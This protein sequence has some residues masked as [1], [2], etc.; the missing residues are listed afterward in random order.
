MFRLFICILPVVLVSV[1]VHADIAGRSDRIIAVVS[2]RPIHYTELLRE[3]HSRRWVVAEPARDGET[4]EDYWLKRQGD[5]TRLQRLYQRALQSLKAQKVQEQLL[6]SHGLWSYADDAAFRRHLGEVN[7]ERT[8][9]KGK[10]LIYG[11]DQY[12]TQTFFEYQNNTALIR[13]KEILVA[14]GTL[15][16]TEEALRAQYAEMKKG[17]YEREK[18]TFDAY[19]RQVIA[20]HMEQAYSSWFRQQVAA[21]GI[22]QQRVPDQHE[23]YRRL[24]GLPPV[25]KPASPA[26]SAQ[27]ATYYVDNFSGNDGNDGRQPDQAW[28][29]LKKVNSVTF[30]PGNRILFRRGGIWFG[31]LTPQ[32]SGSAEAPIAI[33]A[34]GNGPKPLF[35]GNG[36][37]GSGVVSLY[38]QSY[39]EISDL[40]IVNPAPEEGDR[41]GVEIKAENAGVIRHIR[42]NELHIHDISGIRGHDYSSKKTAGIYIAVVDDRQHPTRFDDIRVTHC[43]LHHIS[44]QGIVTNNERNHKDYPGTEKWQ[45]QKFTAVSI[46]QNVLHHIAKNAMIVRLTENGLVEHNLCYETALGMSGNTMFTISSL[47]TTFQYN[48]GFLN[49]STD[50]DGSL[51]DPDLSSPG[52]IWQ[53]SYSHNNSHGL[54]WFCT[55]LSDTGI[56]VRHNISSNDHGYLV[57][58]NYAFSGASIYGNTFHIGEQR[59]PVIIRENPGNTH[60]YEFSGNRIYNYSAG[61]GYDFASPENQ[62]QHRT[63]VNNRYHGI[64]PPPAEQSPKQ[65]ASTSLP[66]ADPPYGYY[67]VATWFQVDRPPAE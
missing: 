67:D 23:L 17:P 7:L 58:A 24:H 63:L 29:T 33:S 59:S 45:Q 4:A 47:G 21:A 54:V 55:R 2:G 13:F 3:M 38:N 39:W 5:S 28:K 34:Y 48:E 65:P 64:A 25:E 51:Y 8:A 66:K 14:N 37:T 62:K 46:R 52:T 56:V 32:G 31:K 44:N 53:Y 1:S 11:P 60:V 20:A 6:A 43:L 9:Q 10:H 57:Y 61:T 40:E 12:T 42:L 35:H 18:Y 41:R 15:P 50:A 19:K 49:R 30:K 16:V 26:A 22:R 36:L 27:G